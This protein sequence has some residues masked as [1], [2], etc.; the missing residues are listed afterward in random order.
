MPNETLARRYAQAIF[1][2]AAEAGKVP[3]IGRALQS[4]LETLHREPDT[5]AFFISPVVD[6]ELKQKVLVEAF[7]GKTE[8]IAFHTLLLLVRKHRE[9]L[10][11]ELVE[12]YGALELAASGREKLTLV[13]A[14][15][16]PRDVVDGIV[17]RLSKRYGKVFEVAQQVEPRLLGG[18]QIRIGDLAVDGTLEGVLEDV[19]RR[20]YAHDS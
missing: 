14:R 5:W 13:T 1:E 19:R 10:L 7:E 17:A 9:R 11:P 3:E 4:A 12:Q 20:M 2:L 18:V 8:E 15:E 6:R 16:L